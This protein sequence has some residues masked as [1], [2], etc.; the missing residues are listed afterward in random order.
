LYTSSR[1]GRAEVVGDPEPVS[2]VEIYI[3]LKPVEEWTTAPN[4]QALQE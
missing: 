4:R 3:G 2:N 1:A